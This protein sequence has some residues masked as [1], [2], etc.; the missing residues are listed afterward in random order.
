MPLM[1]ETSQKNGPGLI[2][3]VSSPG[4]KQYMFNVAYGTGMKSVQIYADNLLA[5]S[6]LDRL[7]K[8]VAV[9]LRNAKTKIASISLWPGFFML[10]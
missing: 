4:A 2:V 5:K 6:A 7:A 8:D 9:D 3:F 10:S 1:L